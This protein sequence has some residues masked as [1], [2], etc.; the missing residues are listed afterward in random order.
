M[1]EAI[2]LKRGKVL[3][4]SFPILRYK[5]Y[6]PLSAPAASVAVVA[7]P[8]VIVTGAHHYRRWSYHNCWRCYHDP[9]SRVIVPIWAVI[10]VSITTYIA[11]THAQC[12][13]KKQ[14]SKQVLFHIRNDFRVKKSSVRLLLCYDS[15]VRTFPY[16]ITDFY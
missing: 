11:T 5:N 1:A 3:P 13:C 16:L 12:Q 7:W 10:S 6:V 9:W 14:Q 2:P 4:A 8:P 15:L